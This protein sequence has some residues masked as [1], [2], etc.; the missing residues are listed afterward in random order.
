M[1]EDSGE[2]GGW[3]NEVRGGCAGAWRGRLWLLVGAGDLLQ[4]GLHS[5]DF[6]SVLGDGAVAG[7]LATASDVV[8]HLL[9]PLLGVLFEGNETRGEGLG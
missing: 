9:G 8:D 1:T 7:E 4:A 5:P 2:R 6:A 3:V